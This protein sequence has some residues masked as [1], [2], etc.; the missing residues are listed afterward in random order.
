MSK[1][2]FLWTSS[3]RTWQAVRIDGRKLRFG[4]LTQEVIDDL[5]EERTAVR[6][7]HSACPATPLF[8][9]YQPLPAW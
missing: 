6:P 5:R 7:E 8:G 9:Q 3:S 4:P 2:L 1:H